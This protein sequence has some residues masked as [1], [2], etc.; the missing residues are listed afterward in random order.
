MAAIAMVGALLV[1][2]SQPAQAELFL[3]AYV[4]GSFSSDG[5]LTTQERN[6]N[7]FSLDD[8]VLVGGRLGYWLGFFPYLGVALD[9]SLFTTDLDALSERE[10]FS[11]A[12]LTR[13]PLSG[14]AMLR[15]PLLTSES[16]PQGH[17]QPYV[18]AGPT[19]FLSDLDTEERDV[20]EEDVGLDVRAGLGLRFNHLLG[21]FAEYR[22]TYVDQTFSFSRE[23]VSSVIETDPST[24]HVLAGISLHF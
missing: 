9:V 7:D 3:D 23:G 6:G 18:A 22:F 4:G 1:T 2:M 14:L 12:D 5:E 20:S 15:F 10:T 24:H 21:V 16:V 11:N 8:A 19:V 13:V 17:L